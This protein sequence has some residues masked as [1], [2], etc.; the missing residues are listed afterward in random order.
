MEKQDKQLRALNTSSTQMLVT[1]ALAS[2]RL[3][4]RDWLLAAQLAV[5][6]RQRH[7]ERLEAEQQRC[8]VLETMAITACGPVDPT[9]MPKSV[10]NPSAHPSESINTYE[11]LQ[12]AK[13]QKTLEWPFLPVS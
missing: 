11:V 3:H 8:E 4:G 7:Q 12:H 9:S 13:W 6:Q 1:A 10:A 5:S 2:A